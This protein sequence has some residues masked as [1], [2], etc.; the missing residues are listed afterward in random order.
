M[1]RHP[2][3]ARRLGLQLLVLD[4]LTGLLAVR[5]DQ[6]WSVSG[7][8]AA[9]PGVGLAF[10]AALLEVRGQLTADNWTLSSRNLDSMFVCLFLFCLF[11]CLFILWVFLLLCGFFFCW[12]VFAY[13]PH[14]WFVSSKLS[15]S[16]NASVVTLVR[17]FKDF[18]S[19]SVFSWHFISVRAYVVIFYSHFLFWIFCF[20]CFPFS[21][22]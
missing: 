10:W 22:G 15:I 20:T 8:A 17:E 5:P 19:V 16:F 14:D 9:A 6:R 4:A 21:L 7:C 2:P 3:V 13:S 12:W 11:V 1:P 18:T